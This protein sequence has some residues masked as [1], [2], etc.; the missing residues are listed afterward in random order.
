MLNFTQKKVEM[1]LQGVPGTDM[2]DRET[3]F[4]SHKLAGKLGHCWPEQW[5]NTFLKE[6][7]LFTN[8]HNI[9][10]YDCAVQC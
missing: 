3:Q 6:K 9:M 10:E 7:I 4:L 1:Y 2:T 5:E 8:N